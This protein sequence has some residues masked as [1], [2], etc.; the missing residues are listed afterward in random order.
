MRVRIFSLKFGKCN[1]SKPCA[2]TLNSYGFEVYYFLDDTSEE[3][4]ILLLKYSIRTIQKY[5]ILKSKSVLK[6]MITSMQWNATNQRH[7]E[8][9]CHSMQIQRSNSSN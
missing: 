7:V 4:M 1:F 6:K 3:V 9:L 8:M 5:L 2:C